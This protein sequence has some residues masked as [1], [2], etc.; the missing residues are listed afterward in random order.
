MNW[1]HVLLD[2]TEQPNLLTDVKLNRE[3]H[4]NRRMVQ[5]LGSGLNVAD[6]DR[7]FVSVRT[8]RRISRNAI[9]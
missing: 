3:G 8:N 6:F 5:W 9:F 1:H 4:A 7:L 2:L